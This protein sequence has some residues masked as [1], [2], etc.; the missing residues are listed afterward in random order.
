[1]LVY[2]RVFPSCLRRMWD[3]R[4]CLLRPAR[5]VPSPALVSAESTMASARS[6]ASARTWCTLLYTVILYIF[7]ILILYIIYIITI[8]QFLIYTYYELENC[9]PQ[10]LHFGHLWNSL[11]LNAQ[12]G[13][14]SL[15]PVLQKTDRDWK[16]AGSVSQHQ[17]AVTCPVL[18]RRQLWK[19][20]D[21]Q[22]HQ[23]R[24]PPKVAGIS[25]C[26]SPSL[27]GSGI[28]QD[29]NATSDIQLTRH[30]SFT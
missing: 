3:T 2:Q 20:C 22:S 8:Y 14:L 11:D 9:W 21:H 15:G 12:T 29:A 27:Q 26:L 6:T 1:M 28:E 17:L 24:S 7:Y 23:A 18:L 10:H 19:Y 25:V 5:M 16:D 30:D 4:N 13:L